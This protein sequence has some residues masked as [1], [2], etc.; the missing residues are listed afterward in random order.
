MIALVQKVISVKLVTPE[1]VVTS[2]KLVTPENV[3]T[4]EKLVI[5]VKVVTQEVFR[6][7]LSALFANFPIKKH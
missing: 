2:V 4:P 7:I 3:V 1:N 5:S 6:F